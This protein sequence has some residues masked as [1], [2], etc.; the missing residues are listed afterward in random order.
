MESLHKMIR[1]ADLPNY[2]GL[3]RTQLDQLIKAGQFPRPVRLSARR[4]AW[5]EAELIAWQQS[6]I[7]GRDGAAT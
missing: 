3:K 2:T 5:I 6:R 1:S 7:A 4:K